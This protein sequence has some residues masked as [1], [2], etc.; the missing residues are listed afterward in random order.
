M[1]LPDRGTFLQTGTLTNQEAAEA[2]AAVRDCVAMNGTVWE[3]ATPYIHPCRTRG[4][5][6]ILYDSVQSSTGQN[7][8]LDMANTYWAEHIKN[9]S[10]TAKGI[11][12]RSTQSEADGGV[13]NERYMTPSLVKRRIDALSNTLGSAAF[14]DGTAAGFDV[15][16]SSSN[17]P[18][19]STV[20]SLISSSSKSR[21]Y[22][23]TSTLVTGSATITAPSGY[24]FMGCNSQVGV[25]ITSIN[26]NGTS[27]TVSTRQGLTD[28]LSFVWVKDV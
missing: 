7:P 24:T 12:E 8:V 26:S 6:D 4:S 10:E 14:E 17:L 3:P 22:T 18:T 1:P 9:A 25:R 28:T 11:V 15:G 16:T 21:S 5:N 20:N 13:D 19:V 2:H 27:L 23:L